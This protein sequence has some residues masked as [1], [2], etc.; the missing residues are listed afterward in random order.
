VFTEPYSELRGD[1]VLPTLGL[2]RWARRHGIREFGF[3]SSLAATGPAL[4]ADGRTL[5][6]REQPLDPAQGGYGVGKW[7]CERLLARAE[8]EGMRVRVFRPGLIL[9]S[10]TTGSCNPKDMLW[11][12]LASGVAVGAHPLDERPMPMAPVDLVSQAVVDLLFT[13]GTAGGAFHLVGREGVSARR[14]F[15]LL[16]AAGLPTKPLSRA[17]WLAAVTDQARAGDNDVLMSMA[18]YDLA[19]HESGDAAVEAEA[20]RPWLAKAGHDP[21]PTGELLRT[22]LSHLAGKDPAYLELLGAD[23]MS[24]TDRDE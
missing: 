7:V 20:W 8:S 19:G 14:L 2:L 16:G 6:R 24:G 13:P 4:G 10:G 5:E 12:M 22:A 23:D 11:R 15:A 9:G 1:N 21:A 17:D 18:L 3:V